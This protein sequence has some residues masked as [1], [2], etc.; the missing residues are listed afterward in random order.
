M[1]NFKPTFIRDWRKARGMTMVELAEKAGM[2][3]GHLSKLE[4][5][6]MPYTQ[7][8]LERV[9]DALRVTPGALIDTAPPKN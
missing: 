1:P 2:H 4:R 9:A 7:Q 8:T 3:Q 5:G 6:L